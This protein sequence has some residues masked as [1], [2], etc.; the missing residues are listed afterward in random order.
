M[1]QAWGEPIKGKKSG[2]RAAEERMG[3]LGLNKQGAQ[4][5][6]KWKRGIMATDPQLGNKA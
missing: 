6:Q 3:E 5:R 4:D 2:R 1:H